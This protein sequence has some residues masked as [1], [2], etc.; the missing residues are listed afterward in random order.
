MEGE[1]ICIYRNG[2]NRSREMPWVSPRDIIFNTVNVT[3][4]VDFYIVS[5]NRVQCM[6]RACIYTA[7]P[8]IYHQQHSNMSSAQQYIIS[9]AAYHQ[10][11]HIISTAPSTSTSTSYPIHLTSFPTPYEFLFFFKKKCHPQH[12][13]PLQKKKKKEREREK[14]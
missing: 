4:F 6:Y 9:T 2:D 5:R 11:S 3:I 14:P 1:G 12:T 8:T 10:H 7:R 13:A